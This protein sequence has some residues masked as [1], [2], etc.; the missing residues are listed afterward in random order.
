MAYAVGRKALGQCDRCGFT[1]KLKDLKYEV[2]DESR[3]GLRVCQEC[4]D[5]DHPQLQ[6]G[7]LNTSDPEALF[8]PRADA[9]EKDSTTYFGFNPVSS[10]GMIAR[11]KAGKVKVV[12]G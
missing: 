1:Y 6:V 5:P 7:K 10:T 2:E 3:N 12:I 8:N 4:F 9:G 11:A